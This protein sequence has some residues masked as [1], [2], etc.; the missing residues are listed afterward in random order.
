LVPPA[1]RLEY[2]GRTVLSEAIVAGVG[3]WCVLSI[4]TACVVG[5]FLRRCSEPRV[6]RPFASVT[7]LP[8]ER[9]VAAR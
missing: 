3:V 5:R 2:T 9:R 8:L 6:A 4:P 1:V 7:R